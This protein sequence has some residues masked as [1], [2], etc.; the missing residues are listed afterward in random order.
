MNTKRFFKTLVSLV[1]AV[2]MLVSVMTSALTAVSAAEI[3]YASTGAAR[4]VYL[5][6]DNLGWGSFYAY[7][8]DSTTVGKD[9]PGYQMTYYNGNYRV[10]IPANAK[11][12][13]FSNNG[14]NQLP[15]ISLTDTSGAYYYDGSKVCEWPTPP[16]DAGLEKGSDVTPELSGDTKTVYVGIISYL[17]RDSKIPQLHYWNSNGLDKKVSLTSTGETV[18]HAVGSS[19]WSNAAKTFTVYK[20]TI[21]VEATNYQSY[22]SSESKYGTPSCTITDGKILLVF[23]YGGTHHNML[24][25]YESD[26]SNV[27][28]PSAPTMPAEYTKICFRDDLS[29]GSIDSGDADMKV[30]FDGSS[31]VLMT[32]T[33]DAM[34]GHDM[35]Y[36]DIPEGATT[37]KFSRTEVIDGSTWNSWSA[38]LSSCKTGLYCATGWDTGSWG[39]A[40]QYYAIPDKKDINNLSFGI[41]ADIKGNSNPYDC[42]ISRKLSS[43]EF[44]LY[45]PA[46]LPEDLKLYTSFASLTI[47]GKDVKDGTVFDFADT[48]S[49]SITYKQTEYDTATKSA[50]LKV[51]K[52]DKSATLLFDTKRPLYTGLNTELSSDFLGYKDAIETSGSVYLYDENG[53]L[54]NSADGATKLKK[55]KGRGNSSFEASMRLYGKYA[56]NFNLDK[57]VA[58]VK[59]A[60]K[61]KKWCLLANNVDLSMMR[62]TFVYALASDVNIKYCPKTRLVDVYDNGYY[63]GAYVITEKVEYGKSTLMADMKNLD[64][65]NEDANIE[66]YNNE[67]IMDD[68]ENHLVQKTSSY[69]TNG[70]TYSYQYTTSDDTTNWP[71]HQPE[72][73][74]EYNFLLEFEL[75]NRYENEA[76]WFVSPRTGQAVVVKYPEFATKDEM[77]W[78]IEEFEKAESAIYSNNTQGI[79]D[80]VDVDSFARM[81][82][83]QE[84]SLNLDSCATSF[85]IHNDL[86]SSKLVSSPVWDYDWAFGAHLSRKF[87]YNGSTVVEN[88]TTL[89][90]PKQTFV[91]N[92]ALKTD[93]NDNT[94]K[95]NYNFQAKLV[96]NSEVW[97]RCRYIWTNEFV[98]A[99]EKYIDNDGNTTHDGIML[100]Q[101]LPS[102]TASVKMNDARWG[103]IKFTGDDWGTKITSNYSDHSFNFYVGENKAG[104]ASRTYENSVYYLN[105]WIATRWNYMS[106]NMGLYDEALVE[107]YELKDV[108]FT[109]E[110]DAQDESKLTVTPSATTTL[111]GNSIDAENITYTVYLGE[112]AVYT[113]D[114]TQNSCVVTLDEG[115]NEVY[116]EVSINGTDL[117][118]KS[119]VQTFTYTA[120]PKV[121]VTLN[122]KSLTSYRYAPTVIVD[123]TQYAMEKPAVADEQTGEEEVYE[124]CWYTATVSVK[125]G[126]ATE[127]TF[128]NASGLNAKTTIKASGDTVLYYGCN[129]L[130]SGDTL[131]DLTRHSTPKYEYMFNFWKSADNMLTNDV[132]DKAIANT[133]I[134]GVK[135]VMGDVT[136]DN[137]LN[138]MDATAI[139]RAL[140]ELSQLNSTTVQ[141]ADFNLDQVVSI[142]DVTEIQFYL[143][144]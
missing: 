9:W 132:S 42:V 8:F 7:F 64:D 123:G 52:S 126:T 135:Y 34:S 70:Q 11:N 127:I 112:K 102:F 66:A 85:Y 56:Y 25:D 143:A 95:S 37:V 14:S 116:V 43:S 108:N 55:I 137:S 26:D 77:K 78:I 100:T 94:K 49:F 120:I 80:A 115:E 71:Y 106:S 59:G 10:E 62:N 61:S 32:K 72:D 110:V 117:T 2:M 131:T 41:W 48:E 30:S 92:K 76:S 75:F 57:K 138:I 88:S 87:V 44:H 96:H 144:Q 21:P 111:N 98:P 125:Q 90:N 29:S 45:L 83:I 15:D 103:A 142:M 124:L 53:E 82:L 28:D 97:E 16:S 89:D 69:T 134:S 121:N 31:K 136:E 35:W 141:L 104:S 20:A 36:A 74:K 50:T 4:Y 54:V 122:F 128:T 6:K 113:A 40:T 1:L 17:I 119:Q 118:E 68:L 101:W 109:A 133:I 65:G 93:S 46:N 130:N 51:Y 129:N 114:F 38:N 23:E 24:K 5:S 22:L 13:V 18:S 39:T 79:K 58:M 139:Q 19:Y 47:D 73:Y 140:V 27:I 63:L 99:L 84:M 107:K 81:Y 105:D 86:E 60:E 3:D 33:V 67:D 91:K 12:V